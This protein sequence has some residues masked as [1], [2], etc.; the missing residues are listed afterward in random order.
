VAPDYD[1][2]L[3]GRLKLR[4]PARG[5]KAGTDTVLLAAAAGAPDGLLVD[6]GAGVG[7]VGLAVAARRPDL[8]AILVEVDPATAALARENILL[9]EL[10]DRV[11]LVEADALSAA[12]RRTAGLAEV[13]ADTLVTNPPWFAP[14]STR[15]SPDADRARAHSAP[16]ADGDPDGLQAWLRAAASLLRPGGRLVA[17]LHI[18]QLASLLAAVPGRF[19]GICIRP[20]QPRAEADATRLLVSGIRGSR[21]PLRLLP[22][23]VVHGPDGRFTEEI[24]AVHR[25]EAQVA[26][27]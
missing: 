16:G 5:H 18:G 6:L 12:A 27:E 14:G 1:V 21:G 3:A 19:G 24:E 20:V 15:T 9:N 10:S 2:L 4:Q 26:L 17:I 7:T 22:P 23:L 13:R 8:R 25:G 11:T